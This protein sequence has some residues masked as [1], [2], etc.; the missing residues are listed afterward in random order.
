MKVRYLGSMSSACDMYRA[1]IP[2]ASLLDKG[3]DVDFAGPDLE[4][5]FKSGS[6]VE[7]E[8]DVLIVPRPLSQFAYDMVVSARQAGIATVVELDDEMDS[9]HKDNAS[10]HAI[11]RGLPWLYKS[12]EACDLLTVSTSRL[13]D[14]YA[15][16]KTV[17]VPN[18]VADGVF[19]IE[20]TEEKWGIGWTGSID[21]HPDDL[22]VVGTSLRKMRNK[23]DVQFRHVGHGDIA[24]IIKTGYT[25]YG[26][27][28]FGEY[29]HTI[30]TFAVGIVPLAPT[31]F[32][33]SKSY[34]K[35][36]EYAAM[37]VPFVAS[38]VAE[39]TF[40]NKAYGIGVLADSEY[41]WY[42]ELRKM[43]RSD[44]ALKELSEEYRQVALDNFRASANDWRWLE[45]WEA[46]LGKVRK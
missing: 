45:A 32:N 17:V 11:Q 41:G 6:G 19:E 46:A 40:L 20:P 10:Y 23:H 14:L 12:I 24:Q 1:S 28:E 33:D 2:F 38:P 26:F 9:V 4:R 43:L 35:G 13:A 8:A 15:P 39:Y 16:D 25:A 22:Q 31:N 37:G 5:A 27:L 42:V 30:N 7:I 44:S 34:L 36:I 29:F 21:V 18:T 3:H